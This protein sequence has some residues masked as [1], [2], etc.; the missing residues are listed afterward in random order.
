MMSH[1]LGNVIAFAVL[2]VALARRKVELTAS[3]PHDGDDDNSSP[4]HQPS[5]SVHAHLQLKACH[6]KLCATLCAVT[7]HG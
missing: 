7:L 4:D 3:E 6:V 2:A 1:W 5:K